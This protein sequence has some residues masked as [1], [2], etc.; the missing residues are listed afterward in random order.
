[1]NVIYIVVWSKSFKVAQY[2]NNE[3]LNECRLYLKN[4]FRL[5]GNIIKARFYNTQGSITTNLIDTTPVLYT[6]GF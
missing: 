4:Q 5:E 1:M 2:L 6:V 3:C